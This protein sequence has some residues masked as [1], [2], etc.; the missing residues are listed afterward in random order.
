MTKTATSTTSTAGTSSNND[1]VPEDDNGHGTHVAG[2]IGA[3][4]NN[5]VGLSGVAWSVQLMPLKAFNA[6]GT[7]ATSAVIAALDYAVANGARLSNN[8]YTGSRLHA[9]RVRRVRRGRGRRPPGDRCRR[10]RRSEHRRSAGLSRFVPAGRRSS[11]SPPPMATT[12]SRASPTS[13]STP[14]RWQRPGSP[15]EARCRG[16]GYGLMSGTSM[17]SPHVAGVAALLAAEHPDWDRHGDPR[18]DPGHDQT[19]RRAGRGRSGPRV[20]WMPPR[21][22]RPRRPCCHRRCPPRLSATVAPPA[23]IRYRDER[24]RQRHELRPPSSTTSPSTAPSVGLTALDFTL[25]GDRPEDASS[26]HPSGP[27][28][29]TR[30]RSAAAPA[31]LVALTLRPASVTDLDG[32][33]GPATDGPAA[34]VH[35]RSVCHRS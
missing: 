26:A 32:A 16:G 6:G 28:R 25:A 10:Q 7:A 22:C 1:A 8:S 11:R 34:I 13:A 23:R 4:G 12:C 14:S 2:T 17:A 18:S 24:Q 30:S 9:Q 33:T 3:R 19:R 29:P 27:E 35:D 5:G 20:S 21:R 15:S 31:G